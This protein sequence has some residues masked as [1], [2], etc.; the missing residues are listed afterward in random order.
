[1]KQFNLYLS[2][3]LL[4]VAL[5]TSQVMAEETQETQQP[6]EAAQSESD[7]LMLCVVEELKKAHDSTTIAELK[8][9]CLDKLSHSEPKV[10]EEEDDVI[11]LAELLSS[12]EEKSE[13]V[14]SRRT[15]AEASTA[16][17]PFVI[18]P[19]KMNY[20]LPVSF[21]DRIHLE[22]YIQN[23]DW[24]DE[25]VET[26]TKLQ[27]SFKVP[28]NTSD[29]FVKDDRLFFGFTLKSWWQVYSDNI[30][31]PFRETNYQPEF[32]Y[33]TPLAL[34]VGQ[35]NSAFAIGIEH[36]SNGRSQGLSRSWNRIYLDW[37][38]EYHDFALSFKPWY[39]IPEE[40]KT[41]PFASDG[42]DNPDIEDFMGYFQL[43]MAYKWD[44]YE[45]HLIGHQNFSTMRGGAQL[46]VTFPLW[47]RLRGYLQYFG[48]YGESMIDYNHSQHRIGIG[49]ALTD[50]L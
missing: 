38:F 18:T 47:G 6:E 23:T 29:I 22:P 43:G 45:F 5:A 30:S 42:D 14:I 34:S 15:K 37:L 35:T 39:R 33:T 9:L 48:G 46:G 12:D 1:M 24:S 10:S 44:E 36:Q 26:E 4:M 21:T 8:D 3:L 11:D 49:F 7:E 2:H 16:F 20:I 27:L 41:D 13:G 40:Q 50:L 17:N 32:F 28:L 31:K 19:H 25:L